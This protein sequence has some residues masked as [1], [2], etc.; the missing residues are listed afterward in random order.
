MI[1]CR[2]VYAEVVR[3]VKK[4]RYLTYQ[5]L[6]NISGLTKR[7][8]GLLLKGD[9]GVAVERVEDLLKSLNVEINIE[10]VK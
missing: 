9:K 6:M 4:E 3:E 5:D 2:K 7:Q 10:V 1:N 8:V